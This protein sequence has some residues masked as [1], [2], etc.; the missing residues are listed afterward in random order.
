MA[1]KLTH[2]EVFR[3]SLSL[4]EHGDEIDHEI[5][6]MLH[7]EEQFRYGCFGAVAPDIFYFYHLL[8]KTKN[9]TGITWGNITHHRKVFEL[10]LTF[11]DRIRNDPANSE[12]R[13]K[14]QAFALGY[15]SHCATDIVTHPYIF[16]ITGDLYSTDEVRSRRA[17]ENHLRVEY[18]L[19]SYLIAERLGMSP[20]KYHFLKFVDI[21]DNNKDMDFDIWQMWVHA[22]SAVHEQ[23]FKDHYIGTLEHIRKG[24]VLN[25][26]FLGFLKFN[27][28][29]DTRSWLVRGFLRAVDNLTLH[30]WK[31]RHLILPPRHRIP[32]KLYNPHKRSWRYP[33]DPEKHSNESFMELVHRAASFS[34]Q[35]IRLSQDYID[36]RKKRKDFEEFLGYNLDTGVRSESLQMH[37][38]EPLED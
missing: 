23:D 29:L 31:A 12:I 33:A 10:V 8:S 13:K 6:R 21:R 17:Q 16:Y 1:A 15:I 35:L 27:R 24:D 22:L 19:D 34:R 25:E 36:G 7:R 5:S 11:L 30:K 14:R 37:A 2:L 26:A 20:N 9:T 3:Q 28:L 4:M 32:E 38:F 18:A